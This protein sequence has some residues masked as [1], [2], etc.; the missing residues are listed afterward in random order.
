MS[1]IAAL[2]AALNR[3]ISK[4]KRQE[5]AVEATRALIEVLQAQI[6]AVKK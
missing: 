3:E 2:T 6:A 4:L 5:E 1:N